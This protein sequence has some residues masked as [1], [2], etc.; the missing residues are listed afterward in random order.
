MIT[1]KEIKETKSQDLLKKVSQL[2]EQVREHRF[3]TISQQER[4]VSARR[5]I[6][7]TIARILTELG[8]RRKSS[9]STD[10]M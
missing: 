4:N 3:A 6:R 2:R 1:S 8:N 7:R 10:K 5:I 9:P